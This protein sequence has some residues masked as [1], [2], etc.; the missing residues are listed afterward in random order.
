MQQN[1]EINVVILGSEYSGKTQIYRRIQNLDFIEDHNT[2]HG[3]NIKVIPYNWENSTIQLKLRDTPGMERYIDFQKEHLKQADIILLIYDV[4]DK[5]SL[6]EV[7]DKWF[8]T[9]KDTCV[10]KQF[11][12]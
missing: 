12:L 4:T 9:I 1:Q 11:V 7:A 8:Q 6:S 10:I 2:T 3:A 5:N